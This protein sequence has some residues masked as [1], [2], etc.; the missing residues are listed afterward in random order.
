MAD[1]L[2]QAEERELAAD[3]QQ[4]AD[5]LRQTSDVTAD[6]ASVVELDQ[7]AVGR[8]SRID[9][10]QQQQMAAEQKR[11]NK[12]RMQQVA[13]ALKTLA[14]G[15]YGFCKRCGEPIGYRRLKAKPESPCC[16]PC[17]AALGR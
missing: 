3:L 7:T 11:R 14:E 2:T 13:V 12:L 8:I 17:T 5:A 6:L 9:A 4:L 16:V 1:E 15:D 10:I